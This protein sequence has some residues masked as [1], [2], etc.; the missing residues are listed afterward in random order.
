[1]IEGLFD[2]CQTLA[3][4]LVCTHK[5][6]GLPGV[7]TLLDQARPDLTKESLQKAAREI[8]RVGLTELAKAVRG[9]VRKVK[10]A[11]MTFTRMW[12]RRRVPQ[13]RRLGH[14]R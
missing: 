4:V 6:L 12:P 2:R 13:W 5:L 14:G 3:E 10:P 1:M 9:H 7:E 8:D 11:P